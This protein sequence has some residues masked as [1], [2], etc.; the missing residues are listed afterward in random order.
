LR[1]KGD[2]RTG[3]QIFS[4][5]PNKFASFG[6]PYPSRIDFRTITKTNIVDAFTVWNPNSAGSYNV[7]A[8]ETYVWNGTNYV[9]GAAIRNY[10][11][12]GEAI[13]VQSNSASAGSITVKESDKGNGSTVVSRVGV[14]RPTLEINMYAKDVDGS[15]YLA[16]GV[17]L[18]F[19]NAYSAGI[20]NNDVRKALNAADNLAIK[21]G[22]YSLVVE[23]R[24][25]LNITDTIKLNLTGT[26]VA[27]YRF[28]I[29]PSV[30]A[31][32]GLEAI[33]KDKFL[34]TETAVSLTDVT[35][36]TFDITTD[37]ASKATDRF[38]IVFKQGATTNFTTIAATRNADKT[39][40]V[41]W[42]TE[43]ERNVNNYTLE[44]SNDGTNFTAIATQTA[45]ANNGTNPTYSKQDAAASKAANW[46]RVKANNTNGTTKYTAIAMVAAVNET[47]QIAE[48][49]MRIYPNPVVGGNVNLHLDN[50]AKGNY[51]V[52]I[53]NAAGQQIQAANVQVEN[54]STLRTIQIGT[55]ATG[56]Y[57]ATIIDET[58]KKT[59]IGFLIK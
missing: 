46:Y 51:A 54:N 5:L 56:T 2:I 15:I 21:N 37:A 4:V 48:A 44:Q 33:L 23:R 34:Q 17:M 49:K 41:N 22:A 11:E 52:Q 30:L 28:E 32:T 25:N 55:A 53:T 57:Q 50:Q 16:D 13:F 12:S 59:T 7:G 6:N 3:S 20:D 10:I 40:A 45:T 8:Y 58:G 1:I 18:N 26:R 39:V 29:D 27:P 43:A 9:R 24:P 31:A 14:T 36:V 35:N 38:I 47:I 42:G 19:D